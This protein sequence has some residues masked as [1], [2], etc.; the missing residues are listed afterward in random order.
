MNIHDKEKLQNFLFQLLSQGSMQEQQ[1]K[2][3]CYW[4]PGFKQFVIFLVYI[5][6]NL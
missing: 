4:P 5:Y 1:K 6:I 2:S 3:T